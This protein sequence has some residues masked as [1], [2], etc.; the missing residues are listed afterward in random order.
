MKLIS[1]LMI[2]GVLLASCKNPNADK[3]LTSELNKNKR[4]ANFLT[5]QEDNA[6]AAMNFYVEL[7]NNSE[8]IDIQRYKDGEPGKEGAI[9]IARFSLDGIPFMCSD[10]FIKHEWTF[11]PAISFYMEVKT[12]AKLISLFNKLSEDGKIFMP[13]DNYGFSEKFGFVED[14]FGISWQLNLGE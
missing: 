7:F 10:S 3:K 6:E 1:A 12:E 8:I 9:K 14:K 11:T 13:L 4:I 2:F 5:F